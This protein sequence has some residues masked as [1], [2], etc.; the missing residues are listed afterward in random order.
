MPL[1]PVAS[2]RIAPGF[3][4]DEVT[5]ETYA[6]GLRQAQASGYLCHAEAEV[7]NHLRSLQICRYLIWSLLRLGCVN[8][9]SGRGL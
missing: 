8:T 3:A 7:G 9:L 4:V 1:T 6:L 5:E 2:M